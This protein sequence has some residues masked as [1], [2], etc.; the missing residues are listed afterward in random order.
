M[1]S[2]QP[3]L[4]VPGPPSARIEDGPNLVLEADPPR[5]LLH[6]EHF[7]TE[8]D[9]FVNLQLIELV[10]GPCWPARETQGSA[11]LVGERDRDGYLETPKNFAIENAR[12]KGGFLEG[13]DFSEVFCCSPMLAVLFRGVLKPLTSFWD[14]QKLIADS[15]GSHRP[16]R[17][18]INQ[19]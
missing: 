17:P 2:G 19:Q 9:S 7:V 11:D 15:V 1:H 14:P 16:R 13:P 6:A 3:R 4:D 10:E 8:S 5:E 12:R 18:S